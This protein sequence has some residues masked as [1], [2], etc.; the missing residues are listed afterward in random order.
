M[1]LIELKIV[2]ILFTEKILRS[3]P[4]F[5]LLTRI[6]IFVG[7]SFLFYYFYIIEKRFFRGL[8]FI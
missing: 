1:D 3:L 7:L 6:I 2:Q 5:S 8:N 4:K